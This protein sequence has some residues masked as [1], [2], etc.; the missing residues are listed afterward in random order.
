[1]RANG[2]YKQVDQTEKRVKDYERA[3]RAILK[4]W[5]DPDCLHTCRWG[6]TTIEICEKVINESR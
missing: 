4:V 3:L 2:T 1:M 5:S 6:R